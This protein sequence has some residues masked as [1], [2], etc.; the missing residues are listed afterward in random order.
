MHHIYETDAYV[1]K[2]LPQGE[3]DALVVLFTE[4]FGLVYARAQ[5][6]RY[7]KSKLR[8][9][10]QLYARVTVSLVRG[11]GVWRLTN[12][13]VGTHVAA[14][15]DHATLATIARIFSLLERLLRGEES[16]PSLFLILDA[17][18][19]FLGTCEA[20]SALRDAEMVLV[21]RLLHQLGYVGGGSALSFYTT[22]N[23]WDDELLTQANKDRSV[24]IKIINHG[25]KESQL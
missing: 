8:F 25:L 22:E 10:V 2:V 4:A 15:Y 20:P 19:R 16:D 6:I 14:L 18:V 12:A 21:L 24:I 11:K 3:A 23:R 9:A 17:G 7:E 1:L 13:Q 5:G